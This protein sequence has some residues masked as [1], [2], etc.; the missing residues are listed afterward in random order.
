M[1]HFF[2]FVLAIYTPSIIRIILHWH[3]INYILLIVPTTSPIVVITSD[4]IDASV[5]R[6]NYCSFSDSAFPKIRLP[7]TSRY[8]LSDTSIYGNNWVWTSTL[9]LKRNQHQRQY[10]IVISKIVFSHPRLQIAPVTAN[11]LSCRY[12]FITVFYRYTQFPCKWFY[13]LFRFLSR[14]FLL[15]QQSHYLRIYLLHFL[16]TL[17]VHFT[18]AY[19]GIQAAARHMNLSVNLSIQRKPM[20]YSHMSDT[21][22]TIQRRPLPESNLTRS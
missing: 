17:Q 21:S 20:R 3:Q 18:Q 1:R 22:S 2:P 7:V 13:P 11:Y 14:R 6:S 9:T 5:R 10:L 15:F 8:T 4:I 12:I 19:H 16:Q